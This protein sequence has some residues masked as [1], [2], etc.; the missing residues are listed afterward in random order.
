MADLEK[1]YMGINLTYRLLHKPGSGCNNYCL[2]Q[3]NSKGACLRQ[4]IQLI[5]ASPTRYKPGSLII[6][7]YP[8]QVPEAQF[9]EGTYG[10]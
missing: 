2:F 9:G 6:R 1:G 10:Y 4:R 5:R 8:L 7:V 3:S